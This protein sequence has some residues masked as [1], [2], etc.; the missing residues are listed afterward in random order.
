MVPRRTLR[1]DLARFVALAAALA[2]VTGA[3][4]AGQRYYYCAPME[5]VARDECCASREHGREDARVSIGEAA[6]RCCQPRVFDAG[7][8]GAT[9]AV[10]AVTPPPALAVVAI[11]D[12]LAPV[13]AQVKARAAH[14]SRAGPTRAGPLAWRTTIDVSLS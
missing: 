12:A 5:R 9:P 7:D 4:L 6:H 11:L 13:Q 1:A 2:V 3:W 8:R 14:E 10:P